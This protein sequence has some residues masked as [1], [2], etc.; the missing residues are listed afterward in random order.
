[1]ESDGTVP[2]CEVTV[3]LG[4]P[5]NTSDGRVATVLNLIYTNW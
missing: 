5:F 4:T 1:M 2:Q 3:Q